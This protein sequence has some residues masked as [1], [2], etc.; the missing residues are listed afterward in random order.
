[1]LDKIRRFW[2][3]VAAAC[4][5]AGLILAVVLWPGSSGGR[6]LPPTRAR[7]YAAWR[8][9]LVTGTAGLSDPQA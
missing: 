2:W 4:V 8:A 5:G 3:A 7:A 1:M 6:N 9:C